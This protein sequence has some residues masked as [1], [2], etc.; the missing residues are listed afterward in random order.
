MAVH[1]HYIA[2]I[3]DDD[4]DALILT[5][6]FKELLHDCEFFKFSNHQEFCRFLGKRKY[7]PVAILVD[8]YLAGDNGDNVCKELTKNQMLLNSRLFIYS[9]NEIPVSHRKSIG[10]TIEFI[11]KPG[12]YKDAV[13]LATTLVNKFCSALETN[14]ATTRKGE[15]RTF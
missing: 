5:D 1:K 15:P 12:N 4:E 9:G 8:F 2:L 3:D 7:P 11:L 14:P 6:A 10:D 13:A